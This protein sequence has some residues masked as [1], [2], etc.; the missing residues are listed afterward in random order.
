MQFPKDYADHTKL[1][2]AAIEAAVKGRDRDKVIAGA[3]MML[4]FICQQVG[5]DART[6]QQLLDAVESPSDPWEKE[7]LDEFRLMWE[8]HIEH[9]RVNV[10]P[11]FRN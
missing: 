2:Q 7:S 9:I 6:F 8:R 1:V 4:S 5:L 11:N 10:D 3:I